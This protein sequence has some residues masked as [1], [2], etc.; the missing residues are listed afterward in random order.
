LNATVENLEQSGLARTVRSNQA[1]P[2][3]FGNRERNVLE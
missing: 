3:P 1:D 2:F